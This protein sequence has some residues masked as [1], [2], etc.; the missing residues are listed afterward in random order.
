MK[1][2]QKTCAIVDWEEDARRRRGRPIDDKSIAVLWKVYQHDILAWIAIKDKQQAE[3]ERSYQSF[4]HDVEFE[5]SAHFIARNGCRMRID[6]RQS[7]RDRSELDE[8]VRYFQTYEV[9]DEFY[10]ME[11]FLC[12]RFEIACD[13]DDDDDPSH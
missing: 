3:I 2:K 11:S 10:E 6:F 12:G 5:T 13:D 8:P 9:V 7:R 4:L 1:H